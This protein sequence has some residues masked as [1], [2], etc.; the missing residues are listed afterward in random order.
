MITSYFYFLDVVVGLIFSIGYLIER[1]TLTA[2]Q[3]ILLGARRIRSTRLD[4]LNGIG[5][6]HHG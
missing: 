6:S 4:E 2:N 5:E 1:P 3:R